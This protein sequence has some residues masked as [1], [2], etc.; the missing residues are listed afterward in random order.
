[1]IDLF[2]YHL[3][4]GTE[5]PELY[6]LFLKNRK[7][8]LTIA[9]K[10]KLDDN[11]YYKVLE[12]IIGYSEKYNKLPENAKKLRDFIKNS[13]DLD[14]T[15][16]WTASLVNALK[17]LNN[18]D[19]TRL[20]LCGDF[21]VMIDN[22][23]NDARKDWMLFTARRFCDIVVNGP[24]LQQEKKGK[25]KVQSGP[26]D[27]KTY[28]L[29]ELMHDVNS[30]TEIEAGLLHENVDKVAISLD[31]RL[32]E[33]N[34]EGR[35]KTGWDHVDQAIIIGRQALRYIGIAGMSGDG[36]STILNTLVYNFLRGGK[37]GLY[38]SFEH[39]PLEIWEFMAFLHSAH[40]DYVD[41]E[42]QLP[43]LTEWD[44]AKDPESGV[45]VTKEHMEFMGQL[46]KDIQ[47]RKNLPGLLD[48]QDASRIATFDQ[49]VAHLEAF[50][51]KYQYDFAVIDYMA[52]MDVGG[53]ARWREKEIGSIIHRGQ[54]LTRT[55]D[56]GKG[57]V[58][59]TPMQI[60]R[61]AHKQAGREAKDAAEN[62]N[63][64]LLVPYDINAV[65]NFSEYQHDLDY[66][67]AVYSTEDMKKNYQ[68]LMQTLKV[69]K[70]KRPKQMM[71]K[72]DQVSGM[73][74]PYVGK[75]PTKA[76]SSIME[77]GDDELPPSTDTPK[78]EVIDFGI[79]MGDGK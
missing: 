3:L 28:L 19:E 25:D 46:L 33:E 70:G 29:S 11:E 74:A 15:E 77:E 67:F 26:N 43:S 55:F 34:A 16:S 20:K 71:M 21:N 9:Q 31:S 48:V 42:M 27:A 32:A 51:E 79:D 63:E 40:P 75:E 36:K 13:P 30:Q 47:S 6:E 38:L 57:L 23:I 72:I 54:L 24:T 44:L 52:R 14:V 10:P 64:G 17:E 41:W 39:S 66:I 58:L 60:N 61:E 18:M 59:V 2:V 76:V 37:N 5:N 73:V 12:F 1:L 49:F 78:S 50:N 53:D 45:T 62:Q 4:S 69:R 7:T 22:V 56:N 35:I 65:A 8:L 68:M